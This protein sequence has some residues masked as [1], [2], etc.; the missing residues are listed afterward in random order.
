[1]T[2]SP[3]LPPSSNVSDAPSG[4]PQSMR[5]GSLQSRRWADRRLA[6]HFGETNL[7]RKPKRFQGESRLSS[8]AAKVADRWFGKPW[9]RLR[10][11]LD[12]TRLAGPDDAPGE[13]FGFYGQG[14]V[15]PHPLA[16]RAD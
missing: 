12:Y 2:A 16:P 8:D 3:A 11:Q 15:F 14:R 5:F 4:R 9:E 10:P 6:K 13:A 7:G 1:M